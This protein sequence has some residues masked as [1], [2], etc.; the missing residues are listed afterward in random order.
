MKDFKRLGY[1]VTACAPLD[2]HAEEVKNQL[3]RSNIEFISIQLKKTGL[4]AFSDLTAFISFYRILL[5]IKPEIVYLYN[6]KPVIYGSIAAKLTGTRKIHSTITG[7]GSV[8]ISNQIMM[9][10]LRRLIEGLYKIG[11]RFNTK[12]FFQNPDDLNFFVARRIVS[13]DKAFLVNGSGVDLSYYSIAPLPKKISFIMVARLMKD[14]GIHEYLEAC[15]N[16]KERY[17]NIVCYLFG[18]LDANPSSLT[19]KDLNC[20]VDRKIVNYIDGLTDVRAALAKASVFVLPSYREGTS[21]A[22]LEAMATGR[23]IITTDAP[24]CRETV[25]N[26]INGYLVPVRNSIALANA[27]EKFIL[28]PKIIQRMGKESRR[29]VEEK[30]DVKKVNKTI[31]KAMEV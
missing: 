7:L 21:R 19:K 8:F 30:Y 6:I 15:K 9:R 23:P 24:G 2:A 27:M 22:T 1:R 31:I 16:L 28:H 3:K 17:P 25:V 12:I 29:I 18:N 13:K 14:K 5:K 10:A 11:L 26:G 20:L 4:N